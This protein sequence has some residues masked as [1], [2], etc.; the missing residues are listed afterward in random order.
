MWVG[1]S[2]TIQLRD[3]MY[4]SRLNSNEGLT[5]TLQI[6]GTFIS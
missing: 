6:G 2:L 5:L 4:N 1:L 3:I